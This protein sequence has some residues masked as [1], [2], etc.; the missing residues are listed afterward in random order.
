[1]DENDEK[2]RRNQ[3][4]STIV[5]LTNIVYLL[6]EWRQPLIRVVVRVS[7]LVCVHVYSVCAHVRV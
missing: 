2:S 1:M 3:D 4:Y 6:C 7:V 5:S